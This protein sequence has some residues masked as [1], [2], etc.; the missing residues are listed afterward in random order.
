MYFFLQPWYQQQ[1]MS[2][3]KGTAKG[4]KQNYIETEWGNNVEERKY[5]VPTQFYD[6]YKRSP[7]ANWDVTRR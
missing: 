3:M 6:S 4:K 5:G 1:F 2:K 7:H